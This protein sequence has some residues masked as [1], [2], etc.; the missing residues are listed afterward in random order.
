MTPSRKAT[1]LFDVTCLLLA[2]YLL[3]RL[4]NLWVAVELSQAAGR[5]TRAASLEPPTIHSEKKVG[6]EATNRSLPF[7]SRPRTERPE[8][9]VGRK[10][11]QLGEPFEFPDRHDE[12]PPMLCRPHRKGSDTSFER[13]L[14][15]TAE[16]DV[17]LFFCVPQRFSF[18]EENFLCALVENGVI[19][20]WAHV[21]VHD[22]DLHLIA[23][24]EGLSETTPCWL[25][26]D[27]ISP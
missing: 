17:A 26:S 4:L 25:L 12:V 16:D 1:W 20:H 2:A 11:D 24:S 15:R 6:S 9:L 8:R 3:A 18:H 7:P 13:E 14:L 23:T 5:A 19:R 22:L 21:V 10:L 27:R